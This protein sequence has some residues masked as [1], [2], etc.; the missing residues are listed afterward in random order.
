MPG[1]RDLSDHEDVLRLPGGSTPHKSEKSG[2]RFHIAGIRLRGVVEDKHRGITRQGLEAVVAA[3]LGSSQTT[4]IGQLRDIA[5]ALT[6]YYRSKGYVLARAYVPRQTVDD[7]IVAISII[8]GLLGDVKPVG[9]KRYGANILRKPF[10]PLLDRPVVRD[11]IETALLVLRDYPGLDSTGVFS[12]GSKPGAADL[13][14]VVKREDPHELYLTVDNHGSEYLGKYRARADWIWNN[15][16]GKADQLTVAGLYT[17]DPENSVYGA[18]H[19]GIPWFPRKWRTPV[20]FG[21]GATYN[22]FDVGRRLAALGLHGETERAGLSMTRDFIR[23]R[24]F[25]LTGKLSFD[26]KRAQVKRKS[27]KLSQDDLSV[28]VGSLS[29][30]AQDAAIFGLPGVSRANLDWSVGLPGFLGAMPAGGDPQS[31]RVG[32]SGDR[33]GGDFNKVRISF[34]RLQRLGRDVSVLVRLDGQWSNDLLVSLEQFPM[35]GPESVRAYPLSSFLTDSGYLG[36]LEVRL[37]TPFLKGAWRDVFDLSVFADY[38]KGR[39]NDPL[40][41]DI[42]KVAMSGAGVG[43][44]VNVSDRFRLVATAARPIGQRPPGYENDDST[45]YYMS[46]SAQL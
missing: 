17:L 18:L 12:R 9:N 5:D 29:V 11:R 2:P 4:S 3:M 1:R 45:Q 39:V 8:P 43:L 6:R 19:Y 25:D 28:A 13:K 23:S 22:Q 41:S 7:G 16:L 34:D 21:I 33:S 20:L 38:A 37:G 36:S 46:L 14:V 44:T 35:G 40:P 27:Q 31:S 32:G 42:D 15:P 24:L 26:R 10:L 30:R